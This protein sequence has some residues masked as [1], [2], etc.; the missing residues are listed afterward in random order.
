MD[1]PIEMATALP[2]GAATMGPAMAAMRAY[3]RYLYELLA[4]ALG[5]R[6][7]EIGVGHGNY[8]EW[9]LER[10]DVL[11]VDIDEPCLAVARERFGP[12]GLQTE[13]MDLSDPVSIAACAW[14]APDSVVC[15]N[16][17][18]HIQDDDAALRGLAA[19]VTTSGTLGLI[20]PAHQALYGRMDAEAGHFRRY[21]RHE[22]G[23][24]LARSGWCV[25]S[26][27]YVNA[28][29]AAGW[30]WHNRVRHKAGL[31]D[32]AV[33]RQMLAGD[34]WLPRVARWTD[35]LLGRVCGLSVAAIGRRTAS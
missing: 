8:T 11:G 16:V 34:R 10:G 30:W 23:E 18:E 33:N 29:G 32:A 35:P 1:R 15:V 22:V 5:R 28:L 25:E 2:T 24:L 26:C 31:K 4:P 27:R 17:L 7:L 6:I 13:R 20:V 14:F 19:I 3:P 21:S 9:L 12:R